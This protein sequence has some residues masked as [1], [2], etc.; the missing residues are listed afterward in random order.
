MKVLLFFTVL[1]ITSRAAHHSIVHWT[2]FHDT[3]VH[4]SIDDQHIAGK[5]LYSSV[6]G[7]MQ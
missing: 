2:P 6:L 3:P 4:I 7:L 1:I 5:P